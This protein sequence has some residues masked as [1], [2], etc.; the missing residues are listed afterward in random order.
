MHN[1]IMIRTTFILLLTL[2]N[3]GIILSAL[4]LVRD[5]PR[6]LFVFFHYGLNIIVF[7]LVFGLFYKYIGSPNPFTT[8]IT[9]MA[10]LFLYEFVFWKFVYSGDPMQYLTFIDWIVPAFLI[11]STI[12]LVGIY[13]S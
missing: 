4:S 10:G 6:P 1:G 5:M 7:G 3:W 12:Y 2:L 11:A 9:A 13:L 8:T